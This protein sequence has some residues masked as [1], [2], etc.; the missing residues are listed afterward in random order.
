MGGYRDRG[1]ARAREKMAAVRRRH[2]RPKGVVK[3]VL[4]LAEACYEHRGTDDLVHVLRR[5][6]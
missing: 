6:P 4:D 5:A 2:G 1:R 3:T